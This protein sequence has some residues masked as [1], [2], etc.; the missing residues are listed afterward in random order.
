[1]QYFR[2]HL[3]GVVPLLFAHLPA[4]PTRTLV[5]RGGRKEE[6]DGEEYVGIT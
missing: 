3:T 4:A 1:M 6:E 2:P 5:K